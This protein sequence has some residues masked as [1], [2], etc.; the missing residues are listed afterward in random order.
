MNNIWKTSD[1]NIFEKYMNENN[2]K[3][4]FVVLSLTND[5]NIKRDIKEYSL[6]FKNIKFIYIQIDEQNINDR[7]KYKK[8]TFNGKKITLIDDNIENYP[9]IY[10]LMK[11]EIITQTPYSLINELFVHDKLKKILK[12]YKIINLNETFEALYKN[13]IEK[14]IVKKTEKINC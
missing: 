4:I 2:D 6:K 1:V 10:L 7:N 11:G 12:K 13:F 8:Y 9:I 3:L 14:I 5:N